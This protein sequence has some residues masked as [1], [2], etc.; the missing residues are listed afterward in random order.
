MAEQPKSEEPNPFE[1]PRAVSQQDHKRK[2]SPGLMTVGSVLSVV[3]AFITFFAV[4]G[5]ATGV[6]T[7]IGSGMGQWL[8]GMQLGKLIGLGLG[9]WAASRIRRRFWQWWNPE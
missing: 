3:S 2:L 8:A 5:T 9:I 6:G 4:C 1:S 7:L